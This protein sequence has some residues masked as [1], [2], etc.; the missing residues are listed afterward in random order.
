M[1]TPEASQ[2]VRHREMQLK[3][4]GRYCCTLLETENHTDRPCHLLRRAWLSSTTG[5][6]GERRKVADVICL[7]REVEYNTYSMWPGLS[8]YRCL[9]QRAEY[10]HIVKNKMVRFQNRRALSQLRTSYRATGNT[11]PLWH[12]LVYVPLLKLEV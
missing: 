9:P 11:G 4:T 1:S 10:L 8:T 5:Q 6:S 3:S 2:V 7:K 12:L